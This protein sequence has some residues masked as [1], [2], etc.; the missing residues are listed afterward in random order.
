MPVKKLNIRQGDEVLVIAGKDRSFKG[1]PR[2]GKILEVHPE[3]GRVVVDGINIVKK[4]TRQTQQVRQAGIVQQPGAI[5]ASNVMLVCPNCDAATRVA[6]RRR[7]DGRSVRVCRKC[8][9]NIDE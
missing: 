5:A 9:K 3:K 7:A 2:R 6:R 1:R 8:K 4:A